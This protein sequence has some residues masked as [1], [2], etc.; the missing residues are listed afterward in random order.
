MFL[1]KK[2]AIDI[3]FPDKYS[4]SIID[5]S[6]LKVNYIQLVEKF[7]NDTFLYDQNACSSP[8][9]VLWYGKNKKQF[10][11]FFWKTLAELVQKKYHFPTIAKINK[12]EKSILDNI[13]LEGDI[14]TY[15]VNNVLQIVKLKKIINNVD[16]CRGKWGYFYE[17]D[18]NNL[19][20]INKFCNDKFQTL[21]YFTKKNSKLNNYLKEFYFNGVT[22]IVPIGKALEIDLN[23]DGNDIIRILSKKINKETL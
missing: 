8:H 21:T 16:Q 17:F 23:W 14:T 7:Y 15:T 4:F 13:L 3:N 10:K 9:L 11:E 20:Q 2:N 12:L 6:S 18:L 22:R 5:T 19:N 1:Q